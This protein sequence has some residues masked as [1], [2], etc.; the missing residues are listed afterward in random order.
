MVVRL[1]RLAEGLY[2]TYALLELKDDILRLTAP[3][4][5]QTAQWRDAV[6]LI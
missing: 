6:E 3:C 1:T 4:G 2:K 5:E